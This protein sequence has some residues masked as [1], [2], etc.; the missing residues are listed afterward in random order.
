MEEK[1]NNTRNKRKHVLW[2]EV[3]QRQ[4]EIVEWHRRRIKL[5]MMMIMRQISPEV[6]DLESRIWIVPYTL[7]SEGS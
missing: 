2:Q 5:K 1:K 6:G 3:P 4:K 7:G